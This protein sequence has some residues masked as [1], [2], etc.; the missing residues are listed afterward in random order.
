TFKGSMTNLSLESKAELHSNWILCPWASLFNAPCTSTLRVT[1]TNLS[2]MPQSACILTRGCFCKMAIGRNSD[3]HAQVRRS[4]RGISKSESSH[5]KH[6]L[7]VRKCLWE[8]GKDARSSRG[9]EFPAREAQ[10]QLPLANDYC[11]RLHRNG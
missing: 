9:T 10:E 1:M 4:N 8:I 7:D 11:C 6:Q 5:R 3:S 2:R